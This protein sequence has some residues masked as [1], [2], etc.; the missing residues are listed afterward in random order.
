MASLCKDDE[1]NDCRGQSMNKGAKHFMQE[2]SI[3]LGNHPEKQSILLEY[4]SHIAA[5]IQD[6]VIKNDES[7]DA[8]QSV[9][10]TPKNIAAAWRQEV[11][12][13]SQGAKWLFIWCNICLF[14]GG[15]LLTAGYHLFDWQW[16]SILWKNLADA[17]FPIM[18]GYTIFWILLGFEMGK[19]FGYTGR[20]LLKRTFAVA[21]IPNLILMVLVV[22]KIIPSVW[23]DPL[24]SAPF[25][26][27]CVIFTGIF[28]PICLA[29]Y[30]W[31][32]KMSV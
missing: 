24:L 22:L 11:G 25:I 32:R 16:L 5:L 19:E 9:L 3:A 4:E 29:G 1:Q 15:I 10:G 13:T 17:S 7:A 18:I 8:I 20:R 27:F 2:L 31:G 14:I 26:V 28:Y 6:G 30:H 12:I 21:I 23:F